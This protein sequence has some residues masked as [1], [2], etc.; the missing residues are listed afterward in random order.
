MSFPK[1]SLLI[2]PLLLLA[3]IG[4]G[5]KVPASTA[6]RM[7][8]DHF[9]GLAASDYAHLKGVG[10]SNFIHSLG[11]Y[12]SHRV[13]DVKEYDSP[14]QTKR[15]VVFCES[16]YA[17]NAAKERFTITFDKHGRLAMGQMIEL[18]R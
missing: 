3:G 18:T 12:K 2:A 17:S 9:A 10:I 4:C 16:E 1:L 7:V 13:V 5:P 14:F 11:S 6:E 8:K 15:V